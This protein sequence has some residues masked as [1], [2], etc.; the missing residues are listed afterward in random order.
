MIDENKVVLFVDDDKQIRES[1]EQW[2]QLADFEVIACDSASSALKKLHRDF[3]GILMT[4][5]KMPD[6]DGIE[7]MRMAL[8]KIPDLPVILVSAHGDI[9]MAVQAMQDGAYDF[10]EKPFIPERLSETVK[11]ACEKRRLYLENIKLRHHINTQSDI[12]ARII[13]V[14][15]AMK[16]LKEKVINIADT[17]ANV[18]IYGETGSGKELLSQCLHDFSSRSKYPFVPINCGAIPEA[19][20][21][22][23]LFGHEKGAFT[24]AKKKRIGKIEHSNKG[25]L[26]LDEIESMPISFQIKLLRT[27]QEGKIQHLGSNSE[28]EIDTR[29]ISASKSDLLAESNDGEFRADLYYRLAVMELH[30]PPLRER[31]EDI[32]LLFDFFVRETAKTHNFEYSS[33]SSKQLSDL[34]DYHWPGNIRELKNIATRFVLDDRKSNNKIQLLLSRSPSFNGDSTVVDNDEDSSLT[35]QMHIFESRFIEQ[36]LKKHRGNIQAVMQELQLERRTLYNKMA[37]YDLHRA[38][39]LKGSLKDS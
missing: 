13:G 1:T 21:E 8:E 35:S 15:S 28:I 18:V 34:I 31:K 26:F 24:D 32:P 33:L 19:L 7:L 23:E 22:S 17:N 4:D 12:D 39:Y 11:R 30:L 5:V 29:V 36:S 9:T 38:D 14:S 37:K 3:P 2:L 25:S 20:F 27:L 16:R 10:I 6:I